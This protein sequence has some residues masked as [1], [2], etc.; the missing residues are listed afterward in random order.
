SV[1]GS[2]ILVRDGNTSIL[3]PGTYAV[4]G[5]VVTFT[6]SVPYPGNTPIQTFVNNNGLLFDLAGN[7]AFGSNNT[8]TTGAGVVDNTGPQVTSVT[9]ADG[10]SG[11][12]PNAAVVLTFSKALNGNTVNGNTFA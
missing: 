7:T 10:T 8:F 5:A 3:I 4:N 11:I 2:S 6:P 12:G 1:N 9:P